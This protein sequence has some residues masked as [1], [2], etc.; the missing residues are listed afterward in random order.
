M[1]ALVTGA[2]GFLG[3]A[4][5]RALR[6]LRELRTVGI[7]TSVPLAI[8]VLESQQFVSGDYDTG[9][10]GE[11]NS[12]RRV[13]LEEL[14]A[15]AAATHRF[16]RSEQVL[17]GGARDGPGGKSLTAWALIERVQRLGREP[18]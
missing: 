18:R 4:I 9:I 17:E 1:K 5:A 12:D 3:G 6:A 7:I 13:E 10:L 11:L 14:A 8:R 15:L 16:T 2:G